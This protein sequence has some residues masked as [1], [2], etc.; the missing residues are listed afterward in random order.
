NLKELYF[1][2]FFCTL[3]AKRSRVQTKILAWYVPVQTKILAQKIFFATQ[4]PSV[5]SID[6]FFRTCLLCVRIDN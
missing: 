6:G 4:Q 2:K 3:Q 1:N 5:F